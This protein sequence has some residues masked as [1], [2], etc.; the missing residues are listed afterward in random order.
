[1]EYYTTR[2]TD[3]TAPLY[4]LKWKTVYD[5][6]ARKADPRTTLA[7]TLFP[8]FGVFFFS[9]QTIILLRMTSC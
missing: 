2:K 7:M 6:Q 5:N 3:I 9:S 8:L 1:M 4:L